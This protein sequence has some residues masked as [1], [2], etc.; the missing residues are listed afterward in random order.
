MF[1]GG[2][3]CVCVC[4]SVCGGWVYMSVWVWLHV[5]VWVNVCYVRV[6]VGGG[7]SVCGCFFGVWLRVCL[8]GCMCG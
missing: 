8:R 3:M 2:F 1:V 5:C 7:E 4:V 6:C